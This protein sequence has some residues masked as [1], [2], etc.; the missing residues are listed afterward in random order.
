MNEHWGVVPERFTALPVYN[1]LHPKQ[2]AFTEGIYYNT[3][4]V[5]DAGRLFIYRKGKLTF[6][7][8]GSTQAVLADYLTFL[9]SNPLP[10]KTQVAYLSAVADFLR[11]LQEQA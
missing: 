2:R 8:S 3:G 10:E 9:R 7:R 5:H 1:V 6:L 11:F 4:N